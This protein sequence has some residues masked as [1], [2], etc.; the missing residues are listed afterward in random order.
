MVL[1]KTVVEI[2][3]EK[4]AAYCSSV[5]PAFKGLKTKNFTSI[6]IYLKNYV[7]VSIISKR[8]LKYLQRLLL[9]FEV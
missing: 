1:F 8:F 5:F 4:I 3:N 7:A 9:I 6:F 2:E